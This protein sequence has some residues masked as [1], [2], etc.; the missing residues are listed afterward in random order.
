MAEADL[1]GTY[2]T[3]RARLTTAVTTLI[4]GIWAHMYR[5]KD[6]ALEQILRT[7]FAGQAQTVALVD[8]YMAIKTGTQPKGL[9]PSQY[10]VT[11]IRGIPAATV[12]D[13]AWGALGGQINTGAPF[14]NAV[15]SGQASLTRLVRTDLQLS[16]TYSA[17]DWMTSDP[18]VTGWRRVTSGTPCD[19]CA[20]AADAV[21]HTSD[22]MPIHEHCDCT[23]EPVTGDTS[24]TTTDATVRVADDSEIGPRL[25][26]AD[27]AA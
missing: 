17:R 11:A 20:A 2:R 4:A 6:Q 10:T 7:V 12:Y 15:D 3:Q 9:D 21:Y 14:G 5:Q 13:R 8:A 25:L 26:A 24:P 22:L 27:W 19:L 23:V 18:G 1:N 16:Q